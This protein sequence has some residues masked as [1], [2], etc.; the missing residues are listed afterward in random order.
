M[1]VFKSPM[2]AASVFYACLFTPDSQSLVCAGTEDA[3][4]NETAR[5]SVPGL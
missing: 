4:V 2:A 5:V 1:W 3:E